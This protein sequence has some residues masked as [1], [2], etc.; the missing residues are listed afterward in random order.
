MDRLPPPWRRATKRTVPLINSFTASVK[1][2]DVI[3]GELRGMQ[4]VLVTPRLPLG[5]TIAVS[6]LAAHWRSLRVRGAGSCQVPCKP[7]D[8]PE[9]LPK[10]AP[11]QGLC[12]PLA[13]PSAC[14]ALRSWGR[15]AVTRRPGER[16]IVAKTRIEVTQERVKSPLRLP[17]ALLQPIGILLG[18]HQ[19]S[20][21]LSQESRQRMTMAQRSHTP[22]VA[23]RGRPNSRQSSRS[24]QPDDS[25]SQSCL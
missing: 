2:T 3:P 8:A 24:L 1:L 6:V 15:Y 13:L 19:Y 14:S 22:R 18:S 20:H 10:Q 25:P 23:L 12:P 7:L 9:D 21:D 5:D 4:R 11:R 16:L 17:S